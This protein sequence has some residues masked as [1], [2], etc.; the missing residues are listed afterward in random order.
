VRWNVGIG[1]R[2][3]LLLSQIYWEVSSSILF[4]VGWRA[5]SERYERLSILTVPTALIEQ[6]R[7]AYVVVY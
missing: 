3:L 5:G 6:T 4:L 1:F 2:R 7:M